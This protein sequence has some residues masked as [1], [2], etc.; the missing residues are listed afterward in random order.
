V[1]THGLA[2]NREPAGKRVVTERFR[3]FVR[4]EFEDTDTSIGETQFFG[5]G[6]KD[7]IDG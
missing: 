5:G 1:P 3:G 7:V 6:Y 4:E 2:S